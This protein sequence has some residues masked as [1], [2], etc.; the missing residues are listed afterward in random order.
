M[1]DGILGSCTEKASGI[2]RG[3]RFYLAHPPKAESIME[4]GYMMKY[5]RE[6]ECLHCLSEAEISERPSAAS[7]GSGPAYSRGR[8]TGGGFKKEATLRAEWE[9]ALSW[10]VSNTIAL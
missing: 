9:N 3:G 5:Q 10:K 1:R 7:S 2:G 4:E 8:G 6:G